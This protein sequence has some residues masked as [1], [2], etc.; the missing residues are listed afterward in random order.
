MLRAI[1]YVGA[2]SGVPPDPARLTALLSKNSAAIDELEGDKAAVRI[3][4]QELRNML[5]MYRHPIA[6][7]VR[8]MC[9]DLNTLV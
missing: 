5:G 3:V 1:R 9:V 4:L 8:L 2:D 7:D 6:H